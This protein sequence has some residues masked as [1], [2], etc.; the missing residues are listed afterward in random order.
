MNTVKKGQEP[1]DPKLLEDMLQEHHR[2][3]LALVVLAELRKEHCGYTLRKALAAAYGMAIE[4][5][6]LYPLLRR[7]ESKGLLESEW[8][9]E[10]GRRKRAYRLSRM[11]KLF[12][13]TF[14]SKIAV[15]VRHIHSLV[16]EFS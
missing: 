2:A 1:M 4:D 13:T 9:E 14:F 6:T 11:G 10:G 7:L 12:L 16:E 8:Q 5:G 3:N 15:E